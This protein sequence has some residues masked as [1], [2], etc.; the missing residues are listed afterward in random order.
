[1]GRGT[2]H[3]G[4]GTQHPQLLAIICSGLCACA[5]ILYSVIARLEMVVILFQRRL[6]HTKRVSDVAL[7]V[8]AARVANVLDGEA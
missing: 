1:M 4:R 8:L 2:Q 3:P 7:Q 6:T 5:S